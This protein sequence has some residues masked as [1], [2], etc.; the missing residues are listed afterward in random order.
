MQPRVHA[1]DE[2]RPLDVLGTTLLEKAASADMGGAAAVFVST[3]NP[4]GGPPAHVHRTADEFVYVLEGEIEAWIGGRHVVL[5]AGMSATLP[6]AVV[7]RFDN[8]TDRPARVLTVVTPGSGARF[9]DDI[10]RARPQLPE[11][12]DRLAAI[13]ARHDIEFVDPPPA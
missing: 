4:G 2:G 7:H 10:D 3:V 5:G 12:F 11:D 8:C 13:V 1:A 6:R 9:F